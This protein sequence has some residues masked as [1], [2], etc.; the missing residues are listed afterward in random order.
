MEI[1]LYRTPY[2]V[3]TER[4]KKQEEQIMAYFTYASVYYM[5]PI[6]IYLIK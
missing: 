1:L 6:C 3:D 4:K 5:L 2:C